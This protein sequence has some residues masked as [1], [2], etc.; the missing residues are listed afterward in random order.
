MARLPRDFPGVKR[1][2]DSANSSSDETIN[3]GPLCA[4]ACEKREKRSHTHVEDPVVH[5]RV[6]WTTETPT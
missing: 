1:R 5:V 6:W 2:A 3:R 4:Y